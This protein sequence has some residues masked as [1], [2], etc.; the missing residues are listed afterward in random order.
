MVKPRLVNHR[1]ARDPT[2][3]GFKFLIN[4]RLMRRW[5]CSLIF[6]AIK[7]QLRALTNK[8]RHLEQFISRSPE[9]LKES[10]LPSWSSHLVFFASDL[11]SNSWMQIL[12]L[13]LVNRLKSM[14]CRNLVNLRRS[15]C[16]ISEVSDLWFLQ[17]VC[18]TRYKHLQLA[19]KNCIL[20]ISISLRSQVSQMEDFF[21]QINVRKFRKM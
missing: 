17:V 2:N 3:V 14:I 18:A 15:G 10:I 20:Y 11:V 7:V 19:G 4:T 5:N 6:Y 1:F 12:F 13:V 21:F 8:T 9:N 16:K